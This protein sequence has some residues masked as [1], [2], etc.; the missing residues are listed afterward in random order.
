MLSFSIISRQLMTLFDSCVCCC[1]MNDRVLSVN[2]VN[3]ESVDHSEAIARLKDSGNQV[4][5]VV[6]R[7][8]L[9]PNPL[10][11]Q[12]TKVTLQKKNKKDGKLGLVI[13]QG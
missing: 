4:E 7:K 13:E 1:R 10:A 6:K 9:V 11:A 12:P 8:I 3:L 5:L 2:G